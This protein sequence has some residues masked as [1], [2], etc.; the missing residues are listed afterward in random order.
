MAWLALYCK[1]WSYKAL[2]AENQISQ[3][4]CGVGGFPPIIIIPTNELSGLPQFVAT[5]SWLVNKLIV[6]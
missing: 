5:V 3:M 6:Q 2:S 1:R 4:S